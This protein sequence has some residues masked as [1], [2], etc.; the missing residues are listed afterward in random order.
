MTQDEDQLNKTEEP[1]EKKISDALEKGNVPFSREVTYV[2]STLAIAIVSS[3]YG[4]EFVTK[5]ALV[6]RSVFANPTD[7]PL[8]S[9]EDVMRLLFHLTT[10]VGLIMLPVLLTITFFGLISSFA[11]NV[12][13]IVNERIHPKIERIS[14][15]KGLGR[16]FGRHGLQ[17]FLKAIFKFVA[18]AIIAISVTFFHAEWVLSHLLLDGI[19]IPG[20]IHT[21]F[22]TTAFGLVLLISFVGFADLVWVRREWYHKLRMSRQEIKDERKQS[23]GDPIVRMRSQSLA[24]DRARNKMISNVPDATL[25]IANPTH[26][27]VAMRFDPERDNAPLVLAKGKDLI[28]LKIREIAEENEIPVIEDKPL[29][30]SMC[31]VCVVDQEIPVEFFIPIARIVRALNSNESSKYR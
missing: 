29:A 16:L 19:F 8:S 5:I 13:R 27:S 20:T 4:E 10:V 11:Q 30:R 25:V 1:T 9:G 2:V 12:P 6:L 21:L 31:E 3:F 22:A 14:L 24:R 28:A 15:S 18:A 26:Y 23:E 17:E 7:W